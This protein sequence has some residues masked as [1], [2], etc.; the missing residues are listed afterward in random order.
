M[1]SRVSNRSGF[2]E[3]TLKSKSWVNRISPSTTPVISNEASAESSF[4]LTAEILLNLGAPF[5]GSPSEL[6]YAPISRTLPV[7]TGLG[8][9]KIS[10]VTGN[11]P[12][13][14]AGEK[15]CKL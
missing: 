9:P 8:L 6:S 3:L 14:M 7:G 13:P 12:K 11:D 5:N 2:Y 4:M 1:I 10:S 15:F